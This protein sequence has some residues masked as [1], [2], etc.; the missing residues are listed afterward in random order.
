[1]TIKRKVPTIFIRILAICKMMFLGNYL[2][3]R[4]PNSGFFGLLTHPLFALEDRKILVFFKVIRFTVNIWMTCIFTMFIRPAYRSV[5]INRDLVFWLKVDKYFIY[6]A[7]QNYFI[8]TVPVQYEQKC[9]KL[10]DL[11]I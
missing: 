8:I 1:M 9:W 3:I 7:C 2:E 10:S 4:E 5:C 11:N 6:S